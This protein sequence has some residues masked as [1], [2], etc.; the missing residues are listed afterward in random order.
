MIVVVGLPAFVDAPEGQPCAGGQAVAIA[1]AARRRGANVELA[2]KIGGDGTGDALVLALGQAGIGHAALLRDPTRPTPLLVDEPI[3]ANGEPDRDQLEAWDSDSAAPA[4]ST[5]RAASAARA[6]STVTS[7]S[8]ASAALAASAVDPA[9]GDAGFQ[10][11]DRSRL[12]PEDPADRPGLDPADVELALRY[13]PSAGVVVLTDELSPDAVAAGLEGATFWAA[14]AIVI[15]PAGE[16]DAANLGS[17]S[18]EAT[19]LE[20]PGHD[21]GSFAGLVGAFASNLDASA[22]PEPAFADA[23]ATAGWEQVAD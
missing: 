18:S 4:A 21:D 8:T 9:A 6:A 13:L 16:A 11:I 20:A 1:L 10:P 7:T 17:I 23:V 14:R 15:R 22:D 19:I 3:A 2:G 12:L 5:P